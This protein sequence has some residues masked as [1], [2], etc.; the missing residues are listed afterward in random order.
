VHN[1]ASD[2]LNPMISDDFSPQYE[3]A[4]ASVMEHEAPLEF[5]HLYPV[6]E[7]TPVSQVEEEEEYDSEDLD[8]KLSQKLQI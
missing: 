4:K 3:E 7:S 8:D 1:Q 2:T 6:K 5:P